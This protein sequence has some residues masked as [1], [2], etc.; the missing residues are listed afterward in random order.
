MN[1]LAGLQEVPGNLSGP[2]FPHL[3]MGIVFLH[4]LLGELSNL[5]AAA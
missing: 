2:P 1:S 3:K 5:T 4:G